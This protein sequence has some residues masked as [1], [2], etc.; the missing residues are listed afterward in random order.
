MGAYFVL[1]FVAS[2]AFSTIQIGL[3][4][5]LS[6]SITAFVLLCG[7]VLIY[8]NRKFLKRSLALGKINFELGREYLGGITDQMN[9]IKD[10]KS[11]TLEES[12]MSWFRSITKDMQNQQVEYT[13]LKSTSQLYYK[14]ASAVLIA[15][16]I[17]FALMMFNAQAAQLFLV[18]AIFSRL[19]PTVVNMQASMEQIA[20]TIP[21]FKAVIALQKE[22]KIAREFEISNESSVTPLKVEHHIACEQ[23]SFRYDRNKAYYALQN[24][25]IRIPVNQMTAFVGPSRSEERRVG[26]ECSYLYRP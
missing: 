6:P 15:V 22:S 21:S 12:R 8:F 10:I 17:Y 26:N 4:F 5:I 3:A 13:R 14:A 24:I 16:F 11:N 9:G 1:Q 2:I 23:L 19:W 7:L 25:N 18:V 20:T